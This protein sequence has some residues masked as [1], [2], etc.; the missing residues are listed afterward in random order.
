MPELNISDF[1]YQLPNESIALY[2]IKD[3]DTSKLLI[4]KNGVIEDTIFNKITKHIPEHS[5][6][7]FNNTK[8]IRARLIF[9][10]Q[11][12][13]RIE[14]FCLE[15]HLMDISSA[16][17]QVKNCFWK[18]YIG[19]KKRWKGEVLSMTINENNQTI[20]LSAE[21]IKEEED[22]FVVKFSWQPETL[23]FSEVLLKAG[24]IPLPPYIKREAETSDSDYYQ[25]IYANSEGSVAAPTAGLH[26]TPKTFNSFSTKHIKTN[27][28]TL[29]VGAGTFKPVVEND[30]NNHNMHNENFIVS[31]DTLCSLIKENEN[32]IAVGTTTAR[33][34]ESLYWL[35]VKTIID[36]SFS[37]KLLQWDAYKPQYNTSIS[38]SESLEA[39]K[40]QLVNI[41]LD[42]IQATTSLMIVPGYKFRV[43]KG[44]ITNFH[45]PCSTLLFLVSAFIGND[46]KRVYTYAIENNYRFLSYGDCCF[47]MP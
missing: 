45:Q 27:F 20:N 28:I 17:S 39:I 36:D 26:F 33:T 25:T 46:W 13:T 12:G 21:F 14:V 1:D 19:N 18:C 35:G 29:H 9:Y 32:I 47:F 44:L 24:K 8:V 3:R 31:Y 41:S 15:P 37:D 23:T 10:K 30:A 40:K 34:L 42:S 22:V 6:L 16:F 43:I 38:F 11:G 4:Y 7:F 5:N 2:P